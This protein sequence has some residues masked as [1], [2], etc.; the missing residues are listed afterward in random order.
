M[1]SRAGRVSCARCSRLFSREFSSANFSR[2]GAFYEGWKGIA[3][4][5]HAAKVMP[6]GATRSTSKGHSQCKTGP[7]WVH[8]AEAY[9]S[10]MALFSARRPSQVSSTSEALFFSATHLPGWWGWSGRIRAN[11]LQ[12]DALLFHKW[13]LALQILVS[14]YITIKKRELNLGADDNVRQ[15]AILTTNRNWGKHACVCVCNL[16]P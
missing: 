13:R 16:V 11:K 1:K 5:T 9:F 12:F 10:A 15:V 14:Q 8:I 7:I 6:V 3:R 4:T 2:R